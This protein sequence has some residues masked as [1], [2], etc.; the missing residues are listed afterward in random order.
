MIDYAMG[1]RRRERECGKV[2]SERSSRLKL[3]ATGDMDER[4]RNGKSK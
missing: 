2:K 1:M 3:P 4:R